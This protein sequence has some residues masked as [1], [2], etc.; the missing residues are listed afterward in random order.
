MFKRQWIKNL[1]FIFIP[2]MIL[3]GDFIRSP[4]FFKS[5]LNDI[6]PSV[7]E[8]FSNYPVHLG[9][10]QGHEMYVSADEISDHDFLTGLKGMTNGLVV[11]HF[12]TNDGRDSRLGLLT[13]KVRQRLHQDN[14]E[15]EQRFI[16]LL[17]ASTGHKPGHAFSL[18][19]KDSDSAFPISALYIVILSENNADRARAIALENGLKETYKLASMDKIDNLIIPAIGID[20][21]ASNL[22][23]AQFFDAVFDTLPPAHYPTNIFLSWYPGW[24]PGTIVAATRALKAKQNMIFSNQWD[25]AQRLQNP[26]FRIA[27][28]ALALCLLSSSLTIKLDL[29]KF[30]IISSSFL[31]FFYGLW[32]LIGFFSSS[33]NPIVTFWIRVVLVLITSICYRWIV[34]WNIKSLFEQVK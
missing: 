30:L 33:L 11:S 32:S 6:V 5:K 15:F 26:A 13:R 22:P 28:I 19:L 2:I 14:P 34:K 7:Q 1:I 10:W 12:L 25:L 16:Q 29:I 9:R 31:G 17:E 24:L 20:E 4:D 8:G 27:C 23:F 18:N 3:I 21:Q